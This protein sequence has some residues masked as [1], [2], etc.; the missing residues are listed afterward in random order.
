MWRKW[1]FGQ[2]KS[3]ATGLRANKKEE[4][5]IKE[6]GL[7]GNSTIQFP[8]FYYIIRGYKTVNKL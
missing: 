5:M 2:K 3:Q 7:T 1:K 8:A 6:G 4:M